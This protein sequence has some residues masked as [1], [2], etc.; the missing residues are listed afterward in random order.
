M[1]YRL[2][3]N[4][5][6]SGPFTTLQLKEM[7]LKPYDLLWTEGKGAAWQY[8]S[9][10][11]ELKEIAPLVEEQ[12]FNQLYK[13]KEALETAH[14]PAVT[15]KKIKPRF[16]ISNGQ[17]IM[18]EPGNMEVATNGIIKETAPVRLPKET[19]PPVVEEKIAAASEWQNMYSDWQQP[20]KKV[21]NKKEEPVE[22]ETKY[23]ES[24]DDLKKRYAEK[25]LNEKGT[26]SSLFP[27][28]S[29]KQNIT[30]AV[31]L[32]VLAIGGYIGYTL[33]HKNASSQAE[34]K[35]LVERA[36]ITGDNSLTSQPTADAGKANNTQLQA[37]LNKSNGQTNAEKPA[38]EKNVTATVAKNT[39]ENK[40]ADSQKKEAEVM[41][42]SNNTA[43]KPTD[44]TASA[45]NKN[46]EQVK[47]AN[48]LADVNKQVAQ[49]ATAS[50]N[51]VSTPVETKPVV[52][53]NTAKKIDDYISVKRLGWGSTVQNVRLVVN[54]ISDFPIDLA[55]INIQYFDNK[56]KFQK[57][58]TMYVKNIEGG[59]NVEVR[60][61]DSDK[62]ASIKYKVSMVSAD[63]KT[64]Y[65]VAD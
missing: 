41:A 24:L 20:L 9:E 62:S 64:L 22:I 37:G 8:A 55:V 63:Q 65:L 58:E 54:N 51:T 26:K 17:L 2:L 18:I 40:L 23:S 56:G 52:K 46:N 36:D 48:N 12:P 61:P 13:R 50:T 60:V 43:G 39:Y 10:I 49:P 6:E 31:A 21:A 45:N 4:N 47:P 14:Q 53:Q 28:A 7:G 27:S 19:P 33:K 44:K 30:A 34:S 15:A 38:N 25:V 32:L 11:S 42:K 35:T 59:N 1:L 5:K 29:V 57:G 3:R 16:R